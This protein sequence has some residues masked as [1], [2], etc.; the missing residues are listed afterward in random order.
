MGHITF[1]RLTQKATRRLFTLTT[2]QSCLWTAHRDNRGG[3]GVTLGLAEGAW[4]VVQAWQRASDMLPWTVKGRKSG[5]GS[6]GGVPE[7]VDGSRGHRNIVG[8]GDRPKLTVCMCSTGRG[9]HSRGR[10]GFHFKIFQTLCCLRALRS[11]TQLRFFS[12]FSPNLV[13]KMRLWFL[14]PIGILFK[15]LFSDCRTS[16]FFFGE[17]PSHVVPF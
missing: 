9:G 7:E 2:N 16:V 12:A 5:K 8:M 17:T 15:K 10:E 11:N 14:N 13:D 1:P 3:K 4:Q 6:W